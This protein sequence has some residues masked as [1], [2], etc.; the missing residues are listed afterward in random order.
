MRAG[1]TSHAPLSGSITEN[2]QTMSM[3]THTKASTNENNP[4]KESKKVVKTSQ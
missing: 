1:K 4:R 2:Y 3:Q